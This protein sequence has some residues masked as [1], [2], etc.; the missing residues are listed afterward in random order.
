[1]FGLEMNTFNIDDGYAEAIVR[2]L[3]KGLLREKD[4]DNL[5]S[6]TNLEEF[7]V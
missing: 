5:V 6:C 3:S 2:A 4:Y 1:M 7:K